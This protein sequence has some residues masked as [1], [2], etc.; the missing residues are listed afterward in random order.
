MTK[1]E[2][3]FRNIMGQ[4]DSYEIERES[5]SCGSQTDFIIWFRML[6]NQEGLSPK[7]NGSKDEND[8][9]DVRL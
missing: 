3:C 1:M 5:L 4:E 8:P 9:M 2:E 6:A 7:V